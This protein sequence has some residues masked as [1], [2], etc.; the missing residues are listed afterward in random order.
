MTIR[1]ARADSPD[2]HRL[3]TDYFTW[4][5]REFPPA[6]GSYSAVYPDPQAFLE[7][8]GVFL[9]AGDDPAVGCGGARRITPDSEG[10]V[11]FEVK[12]VWLEPESRGRGLADR[13]MG[14]LES[15]AQRL[16]AEVMVLDT[17]HTLEGAARLYAKRGYVAV[18]AY[19]ENPNATVWYAKS[20]G[21]PA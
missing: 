1:E 4:R 5:A 20:L 16:G 17:H 3:L 21:A 6:Q 7:P 19:N 9:I 10:R 2:A 18:E 13:M 8:D 11:R 15:R 14:E 12:H